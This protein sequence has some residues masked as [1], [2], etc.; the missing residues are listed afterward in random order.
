MS[1]ERKCVNEVMR[2]WEEQASEQ[3]SGN[4][5]QVTEYTPPTEQVR[6]VFWSWMT[7]NHKARNIAPADHYDE[8]D[9]WLAEVKAQAWYEGRDAEAER[10]PA[11]TVLNPYRGENK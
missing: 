10:L 1:N 3:L 6:M 2:A 5:G 11:T 8:F 4:P 7:M 9:R